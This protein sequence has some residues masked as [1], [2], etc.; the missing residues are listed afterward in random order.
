VTTPLP[1]LRHDLELMPSPVPDRPGLLLRDPFRYSDTVIIVPPALVPAL[2]CFDGAHS[3]LDLAALLLRITGEIDVQGLSA[4]LWGALSGGGFL[5]DAAF[6]RRRREAEDAF[7]HAERR[8]PVHAGLAYPAAIDDLREVLAGYFNETTARVPPPPSVFAIAAP[9]VSPEGGWR[10][11][12]DAYRAFPDGDGGA[13]FVVLGTSHY[14]TP[15]RFGLT[16][17]PYE[18]PFGACAVDTDAV[19]RLAAAAPEAVVMEDYCHAVEHSIEFQVLFLQHRFGPGVRVLP[20]LCGPFARSLRGGGRPE[21][22]TAVARFIEALGALYA[23]R[24]DALR[25]VIGVDMAHVGRR[26][27][28]RVAARVGE[29]EMHRIEK[30]DRDRLAAVAGGHAEAFW[31]LIADDGDRELRWCGASPLY[32]FLRA[33]PEARGTVLRYEQWNI[34]SQSVVSFAALA[35]NKAF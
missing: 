19:D 13:T 16:R 34:D 9:H 1:A 17:K 3:D 35:F 6:A 14:G 23:E 31:E 33:V 30:R 18:T 26:Y 10:S 2:A 25:F 4:Q 27:G 24:G 22:D 21:D 20:I 8:P 7:A 5:N 12:A 28:D 32:T 11:Y 15:E 29:P